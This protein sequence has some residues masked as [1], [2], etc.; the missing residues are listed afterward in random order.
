MQP[1][2]TMDRTLVAVEVGET[3]HV[4]LELV[5]PAAAAVE[6][7]PIDVVA[8]IDRSGSMGGQPLESVIA[9]TNMLVRLLGPN[10]RIAVVT[11]DDR[12]DLVM[13]LAHHDPTDAAR[14]LSEVHSGG[15]TNLSGGWLKGFEILA[16]HGR[17]EAMKRV[18]VLTDGE[19][20]AGITSRDELAT[21]T[22]GARAQQVT[23][24]M[25]GF[26]E[27][28]DEQLLSTMADAGGG[29]DYWCAG[30]DQAP[31]VFA[32]EFTGLA[33]VVAQNVS[34]E[35]RPTD[36]TDGLLVLNEYPI[37]DVEGGMQ[38]ALGDAF[39]D[40]RR[41][42]VAM[43]HLK[44]TTEIGTVHVADMVIR[45]ASTVG[46]VALHTVV[47]PVTVGAAPG[48]DADRAG[49]DPVVTEEVNVLKIA[50]ARKEANEAA[51]RGDHDAASD[52]LRSVA[53]LTL[54]ARMS[55][56]DLAEFT[57]DVDRLSSGT[58]LEAD[59]KRT[60]SNMRQST[61]G[62]KSRYDDTTNQPKDPF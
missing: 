28:F 25:V 43:L 24:T 45:W 34:V 7:A 14:L 38:V 60:H 10:D 19:A 6:R 53:P 3:V 48:S 49:V 50:R 22:L 8:V 41:R 21:L 58:W 57:T 37:T 62:R 16:A 30:P 39:G 29:N 23:T 12:V 55:D 36:A 32:D 15:S 40:E 33:S 18:I 42:V 11:F 4:M 61:K 5:A 54:H 52:V 27:R 2:V 44:P 59:M 56:A 31:Q 9:A 47:V 1:N 35:I 46:P 51:R 13:P 17:P 26:G 20:N